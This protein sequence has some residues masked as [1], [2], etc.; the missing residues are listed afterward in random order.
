MKVLDYG[1]VVPDSGAS[2]LGPSGAGLTK[3]FGLAD[4]RGGIASVVDYGAV[5]NNATLDTAAFTA[6]MT[7]GKATVI[8]P[9]SPS[10][11][12]YLLNTSIQISSTVRKFL[13]FGGECQW[14]GSNSSANNMFWVDSHTGLMIQGHVFRVSRA[15]FPLVLTLVFYDDQGDTKNIV[16]K[17]NFFDACGAYG[18]HTVHTG[19][20]TMS[21]FTVQGNYLQNFDTR[22]ISLV[23]V[24]GVR[25]I[26]NQVIGDGTATHHS[27]NLS[28]TGLTIARDNYVF[29]N[30]TNGYGLA[31]VDCAPGSVLSG[32][33]V[34]DGLVNSLAVL[35]IGSNV[36]GVVI[37]N[38]VIDQPT[39]AAIDVGISVEVNGTGVT[40]SDCLVQ[41]NI[42][43]RRFNNGILV[44]VFG[45]GNIGTVSNI[46]VIGNQIVNCNLGAFND[47]RDSGIILIHAAG[48]NATSAITKCTVINNEVSDNTGTNTKYAVSEFPSS[49]IINNNVIFGNVGIG[50]SVAAAGNVSS[51]TDLCDGGEQIQILNATRTFTNNT[52]AQAIFNATTNGAV[53]LAPLTLYEFEML[54]AATGFSASAHTINLSFGGTATFTSIG[55]NYRSQ[56]GSTLAGPTAEL[57]GF[58]AAATA[59]AIIA[60]VSTT[61]L[62]LHVRG[63]MR[64]NAGGTVIPQLTQ[65][66]SSAAAVVQV[67]SFFRCRP[68][69][70]NTLTDVG[71]WS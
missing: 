21:N 8:V 13:G 46:A 52:S 39:V 34:I 38:N 1:L 43:K 28:R 48:V 3:R 5:G 31:V 63:I 53:T 47:A 27:I 40:V 26:N 66:T 9:L 55:Y 37:S 60:S 59:T 32:N 14:A 61:G 58:V 30:S 51:S 33:E 24:N 68:L 56:A 17:D 64:I 36:S 71:S 42:V 10:G 45:T 2:V 41:G 15:S 67:N 22:G 18:I 6:A 44:G 70:S 20:G 62:L 11:Q 54:V 49:A 69:G 12:P 16:I 4:L 23:D 57:S 25:V 50:M 7:S 65:V 29:K 35:A 19:A